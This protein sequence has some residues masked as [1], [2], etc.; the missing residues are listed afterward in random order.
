MANLVSKGDANELIIDTAED[1]QVASS[2][3]I[4]DPYNKVKIRKRRRKA[5]GANGREDLASKLLGN[6]SVAYKFNCN[7]R[8]EKKRILS[9]AAPEI[10]FRE[11][12]RLFG[13]GPNQFSE[14]K[15]HA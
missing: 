10:T 5:A 12:I 6:L 11:G 7:K 14:A 15:K 1:L 4:E 8:S 9:I 2:M 3:C 13:C